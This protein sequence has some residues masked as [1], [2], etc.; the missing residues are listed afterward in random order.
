[1]SRIVL[2]LSDLE[3]AAGVLDDAARRLESIASWL[4]G[5]TRST[6]LD[7][8]DPNVRRNQ[9]AEVSFGVT[10]AVRV[11]AGH[12][13][14]DARELRRIAGETEREL[15]IVW[16]G[17]GYLSPVEAF[18]ARLL[19]GAVSLLGWLLSNF[20][21]QTA[22]AFQERWN[23]AME[24][25]TQYQMGTL[26][27]EEFIAWWN[28]LTDAERRYLAV[29]VRLG[30][31]EGVPYRLRFQINDLAAHLEWDLVWRGLSDQERT[32]MDM[33]DEQFSEY[34]RS[35][36][37]TADP[38][39]TIWV[40]DEIRRMRELRQYVGFLREYTTQPHQ[41]LFF[42]PSHEPQMGD[43]GV[44]EYFGDPAASRVSVVVPGLNTNLGNF[45]DFAASAEAM[46]GDHAD[47]AVIAWFDY[48]APDTPTLID[49][50]LGEVLGLA[51]CAWTHENIASLRESSLSSLIT[52]L[53]EGGRSIDLVGHSFGCS[54]VQDFMVSDPAA[55]HVGSV[56]LL[57]VPGVAP[58]FVSTASDMPVFIGRYADD[59]I[60]WLDRGPLG[61]ELGDM[62][63]ATPG[64]LTVD[65]L[66]TLGLPESWHASVD[67]SSPM[68]APAEGEALVH[69][70][71]D[72]VGYMH[73]GAML[74][75]IFLF[76]TSPGYLDA[77]GPEGMDRRVTLDPDGTTVVTYTPPI[78]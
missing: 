34:E 73:Q 77:T 30:N 17:P 75:E 29:E 27:R 5:R 48:D 72:F 59:Q 36:R 54:A 55:S 16:E 7:R 50:K 57:A 28:G 63:N 21:S 38:E 53:G 12:A 74:D 64:G 10:S 35:L 46:R 52:E 23:Q 33:T 39:T 8:G 31:V 40:L 4:A 49:G 24:M 65:E 44:A 62:V 9:P 45:S 15:E 42:R 61:I 58:T 19:Q 3:S 11:A 60:R 76:Q 68:V 41:I 70:R 6:S 32:L 26:S 69:T 71:H 37:Q 22:A 25:V 18:G 13:E 1:V 78:P 14:V 67:A 20:V 66:V 47:R 51:D 56:A 2:D 43:H